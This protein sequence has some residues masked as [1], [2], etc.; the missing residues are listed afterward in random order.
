M[1]PLPRRR[2]FVYT[3]LLGAMFCVG[4]SAQSVPSQSV[5]SQSVG[6]THR[7]RIYGTVTD[8]SGNVIVGADVILQPAGSAAARTLS[9]DGAGFFNFTDL[10]AG[11]YRLRAAHEGFTP[12]QSLRIAL[13]PGQHYSAPAIALPVAAASTSVRVTLSVHDIATEQVHLEEKQRVLGVVPNFYVSYKWNAEPLTV[14]QKFGLGLRTSVDPFT[15]LIAGVI[16]GAQQGLDDF[17]GYGQGAQGYAKRY[18]AAYTDG[19]LGVMLSGAVLPSL[20]HQDPRYFYKGTGT[21]RS[22]ALYALSTAFIARGDSGRWGPNYSNLIGSFATAGISNA[23]YP[24]ASRGLQLTIDNSL[25]GIAGV[26]G[27]A[28]LQEFL[29]RRFSRGLPPVTDTVP[30]K[31][32]F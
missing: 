23:Y 12:S 25:L 24:P 30:H 6:R 19:F 26:A 1:P 3:L 2:A 13:A 10:A 9:T 31:V 14:R 32:H 18:G 16:A 17:P 8:S 27:S 11:T 4:L 22:R 20:F 15:F 29:I 5:S 21:I 28:L 7:G